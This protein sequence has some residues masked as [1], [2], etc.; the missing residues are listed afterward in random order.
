[1]PQAVDIKGVGVV[2]FPDEYT[3]EQITAAIER[4]ILPRAAAGAIPEPAR[5]ER[6]AGENLLRQ[7]G[8]TARHVVEGLAGIPGM[9]ADPISKMAG[10]KPFTEWLSEKLTDIGL[11]QPE[12]ATERVVGDASRGAVGA[13]GGAGVGKL[14]TSAAG[15]VTQGVGRALAAAPVA[16]GVAGAAAGATSGA[17]RE[18]GADPMVQLAIGMATGFL[19]PAMIEAARVAIPAAARGARQ[20]AKPFT[21]AGREEVA[22]AALNRMAANRESAMFN[23]GNN[24]DE[25]IEGSLPTAAQASRD[26][27]LLQAERTLAATDPRFAARKSANNSARNR[28]LDRIAGAPEELAAAKTARSENAAA[29]YGHAEAQE[30]GA[31]VEVEP[32]LNLAKRPAFKTAVKKAAEIAAESGQPV[33][34]VMSSVRGLHYVKMA[35]DDM[36]DTAP[37]S[38]IGKTQQR[39]IAQ[40]R[41]ELVSWLDSASPEYAKARASFRADSAPINRMEAGQDIQA[42]TRLAGPDVTGEPILSQAKWQSVVMRNIDD[43][44][45]KL[46]PDHIDALKRIGADLD[47]AQLSDSAGRA[48]GSNTFQNLSTANVLGA[49]MGGKLATN[50]VAQTMLRPLH[51]LYKMPEEQVRD[52][53]S[54]AMLD[55]SIARALMSKATP[56]NIDFVSDALKF[57]ARTR[58]MALG[59]TIGATEAEEAR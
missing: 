21:A 15:P 10:S 36:L 59:A 6:S 16:Q 26:P 37:Q 23:M 44:G 50:A 43:L 18:E 12:T 45:D 2:R 31:G 34:D 51:W 3:P 9:L 24:A 29:N 1:M 27:G 48:A 35:L 57:A 11:P 17:A 41:E 55:P 7:G 5:P 54:Q 42:R 47:R 14:L 49:A 32:L 4:D 19:T 52:L 33:D 8:L 40:T 30:L 58:G 22:G 38:G 20:V 39:A 25:I 28:V 46:S 13:V 53:L 56:A